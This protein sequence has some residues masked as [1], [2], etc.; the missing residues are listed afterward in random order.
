[1]QEKI[2]PGSLFFQNYDETQAK[3]SENQTAVDLY[4]ETTGGSVILA[5]YLMIMYLALIDQ[6]ARGNKADLLDCY[7]VC[8][9]TIQLIKDFEAQRG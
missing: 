8:R 7:Y 9:E 4:L 1:M 2:N 3:P 6:N 5:K